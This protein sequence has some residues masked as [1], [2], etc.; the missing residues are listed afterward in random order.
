MKNN[1]I[2][3]VNSHTV[4]CEGHGDGLGHPLVYLE[5]KNEQIVCPYCSKTFK[6][7]HHENNTNS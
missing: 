4:K 5:I 7:K 2:T 3:Y 6:I 1:D